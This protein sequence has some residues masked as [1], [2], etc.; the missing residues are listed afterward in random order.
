MKALSWKQ[1]Y[2]NLMFCGKIETRTWPTKYRGPVLIC[3]SKV[4]YTWGEVR[5][6]SGDVQYDRMYKPLLGD[7]VWPND[8]HEGKAI[9]V[10][11]LID[12][13]PM[14]QADEDLCF[15]AY[16]PELF[17]H[18]YENVRRIQSIPW[19]GSQGWRE[20]PQEIIDQIIYL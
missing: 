17:C 3:A 6:I 12:C 4:C 5:K 14:T 10:G 7:G 18:I 11:N 13:R 8:A 1:P 20:V 15:V 16:R 9:G 19:R 2:G